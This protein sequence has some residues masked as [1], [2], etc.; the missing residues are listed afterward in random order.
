LELIERQIL[1]TAYRLFHCSSSKMFNH[2]NCPTLLTALFVFVFLRLS[3]E[4]T[5]STLSLSYPSESICSVW[6]KL[7]KQMQQKLL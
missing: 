2:P 3:Y 6:R 5:L 1:I 4:C 7:G